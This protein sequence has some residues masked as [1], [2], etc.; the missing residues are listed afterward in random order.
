KK[1][2][3]KKVAKKVAKKKVAKKVAKKKVAKKVAKKK[4]AKKVAKKKVAKK[5]A[6]K[7]TKKATKKVAKKETKKAAAKK[8]PK[9]KEAKSKKITKED[10]KITPE[11]IEALDKVN[12]QISELSEDFSWDEIADSI[13]SLDFFVDNKSDECMEK[14]CENL[15]TTQMYCR[16]HYIAN[17][18]EIKKKREILK[19][20]KL[21]VYIEDLISKYPPKYIEAIVSDLEDE[22]DFYKALHALNIATDVDGDDIDYDNLGGDDEGDDIET[23]TRGYGA[24]PQRFE[25][26]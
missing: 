7:V 16:L 22:K 17:W 9:K 25:D 8:E 11:T 15:R 20:G 14:G 13:A 2:A 4:V 24:Q 5:V 21:Q 26:E 12:D 23:D 19:E 3:K 10:V 6:K 1:V 18:H